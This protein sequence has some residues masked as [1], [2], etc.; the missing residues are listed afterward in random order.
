MKGSYWG[1]LTGFFHTQEAEAYV[2]LLDQHL[3]R[4]HTMIFAELLPSTLRPKP[5]F[6]VPGRSNFSLHTSFAKSIVSQWLS[7][8]FVVPD[9]L[10]LRTTYNFHRKKALF[11]NI[12]SNKRSTCKS[13]SF[14]ITRE[15]KNKTWKPNCSICMVLVQGIWVCS[16]FTCAI[17]NRKEIHTGPHSCLPSP[18]KCH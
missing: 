9:S 3:F 11:P 4:F 10:L 5:E 14:T 17:W 13:L 2:T 15:A 18:P 12:C 1:P 7:E 6:S 16:L 8:L